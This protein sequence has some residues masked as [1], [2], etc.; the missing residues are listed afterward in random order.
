M[1]QLTVLR[2]Y[3]MILFVA[4]ILSALSG[5]SV[6]PE[7]ENV[8]ASIIKHFEGRDYRV[9]EIEIEQIN[10]LPLAQR[11][12]MAPEKHTILVALI[13]FEKAGQLPGTGRKSLTF[14]DVVITIRKTGTHGVWQVDHIKGIPLL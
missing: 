13:T 2:I 5:C 14:K 10:R 4:C 8:T 3:I 11:E 9:T 7:A 6:S 1:L 12:Y